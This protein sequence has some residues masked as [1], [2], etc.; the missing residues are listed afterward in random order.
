MING[1]YFILRESFFDRGWRVDSELV[2]LLAIV[3]ARDRIRV[4]G[5][6]AASTLLAAIDAKPNQCIT[7]GSDSYLILIGVLKRV[8]D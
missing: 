3:L 2:E 5:R 6:V 4:R 7:V 1:L 8:A